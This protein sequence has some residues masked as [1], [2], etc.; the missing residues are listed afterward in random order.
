M[1][2]S[3]ASF[4]ICGKYRF[5]LTRRISKSPRKII[6]IGLNPSRA[7]SKN[8]DA[9]LTRLLDF[10]KSWGYGSIIVINLFARISKNPKVLTS[11][12]NP[13]GVSNNVELRKFASTNIVHIH[14]H[15]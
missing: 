6:F 11:C 8:N 2:Y 15:Y 4:S 12:A 7:D 3:N 10:S 14:I 5:N 1:L 13:I 9:T